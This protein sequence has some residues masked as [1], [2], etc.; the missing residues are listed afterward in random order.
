MT[1]PELKLNSSVAAT[2]HGDYFDVAN[3]ANSPRIS[4]NNRPEAKK[5][6]TS[7]AKGNTNFN[8]QEWWNKVGQP[9]YDNLGAIKSAQN[10]GINDPSP[11]KVSNPKSIETSARERY[12]EFFD[13]MD[14]YDKGVINDTPQDVRIMGN[15]L[16]TNGLDFSNVAAVQNWLIKQG[17]NVG[18]MGADG[19]YGANTKA[20]IDKLLA[21][22]IVL[23]EE[24]KNMFRN[25][26]KNSTFYAPKKYT[27]LSLGTFDA[28]EIMKKFD[29]NVA[30]LK[31]Q[32]GGTVQKEQQEV[33]SKEL[34]L[35]L[36]GYMISTKKQPK[37]EKEAQMLAK[38]LIQLKQQD[39]KQFA[40]LVQLGAQVQA[41]KA[42]K[43]AKLNYI[44]Q[45]K[46]SCPDG[47]ELV[48][49]KKGG[50][51]NCGC[52]KKE[53]GGDVK[54]AK[55]ANAIEEFKKGRKSKKC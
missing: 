55:K 31:F 53:K 3:P 44:K 32:Q 43:G 19:K 25:F 33:E 23:S 30:K 13:A 48:Y 51:I 42:E 5:Y 49:F 52:Q 11:V 27:D 2:T 46:G 38:Q 4:S 14:A 10:L 35:A 41:K 26:Q 9:V 54:P 36:I 12:P 20:A 18:A 17:F 22:N 7:T 37:D 15:N 45:L 24:E 29:D 40:E 8:M 39:P 50:M 16:K 1:L 28:N 21:S 34:E 47:E 6:T